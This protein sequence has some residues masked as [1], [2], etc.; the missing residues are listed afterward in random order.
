M[1]ISLDRFSF[2]PYPR[3]RFSGAWK[4]SVVKLKYGICAQ[5][6]RKA[7]L[8]QPVLWNLLTS[9]LPI[10]QD[11]SPK[12]PCA[13]F[14]G[15]YQSFQLPIESLPS[16]CSILSLLQRLSRIFSDGCSRGLT[17]PWKL[18]VF[19]NDLQP[20]VSYSVVSS[21]LTFGNTARGP[22]WYVIDFLGVPVSFLS[23]I[24]G[25]LNACNV[26]R[27]SAIA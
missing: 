2:V 23:V 24:D 21:T 16:Y 6:L 5:V 22:F 7:Q 8:V 9:Y 25:L 13:H 3:P 15:M 18:I 4:I 12:C 14:H 19:A 27:E 20:S 17:V 1:Y 10:A 11:L 26:C